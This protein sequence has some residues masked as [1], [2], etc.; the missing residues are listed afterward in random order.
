MMD[1]RRHESE[2]SRQVSAG[3]MAPGGLLMLR[4]RHVSQ[5]DVPCAGPFLQRSGLRSGDLAPA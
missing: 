1:N 3:C 2:E 4:C 5:A